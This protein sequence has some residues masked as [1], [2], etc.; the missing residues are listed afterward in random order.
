MPSLV[1]FIR[2]LFPPPQPISART[3]VYLRQIVSQLDRSNDIAERRLAIEHPAEYKVM[4]S[5]GTIST[6]PKLSSIG[7]P[8]VEDWNKRYRET[9]PDLYRDEAELEG[10]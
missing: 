2:S 8:T 7:R 5:R 1:N 4:K 3:L 10:G 6:M 9:H